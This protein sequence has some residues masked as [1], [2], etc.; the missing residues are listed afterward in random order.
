[1]PF[2]V[3]NREVLT[4]S[5][6]GELSS[7]HNQWIVDII[8]SVER[9]NRLVKTVNGDFVVIP[10]SPAYVL[11][12]KI[13]RPMIDAVID[14]T[15]RLG[16]VILSGCKWLS[17]VNFPPIAAASEIDCSNETC[18][19]N[20]DHALST[21]GPESIIMRRFA[22][23]FNIASDRLTIDACFEATINACRQ[24]QWQQID[25]VVDELDLLVNSQGRTVLLEL[26]EQGE[27]GLVDEL[28]ENGAMMIHSRDRE[29]NTAL[30][31]AAKNGFVYETLAKI[32]SYTEFTENRLGQTP[33]HFA[34]AAGQAISARGLLDHSGFVDRPCKWK[35]GNDIFLDVTPLA[36][37]VINGQIECADLLLEHG[38]YAKFDISNYGGLLHLA[39]NFGQIDMLDH[40]LKEH[41]NKFDLEQRKDRSG[42]TPLMA[43]AYI[44]DLRAMDILLTKGALINAPDYYGRRAIH[45]ATLSHSRNAIKLLHFH[46][47]E[48]SCQTVNGHTPYDL[49]KS[50]RDKASKSTKALLSSLERQSSQ[51]K[52][53]PAYTF[54]A[55]ENLVFQGGGP[56]CIAY[57]GVLKKLES[58][59]FL[60]ELKRVSGTSA[61]SIMASLV[62]LNYPPSDIENNLKDVDFMSF[63]DHP[64]SKK[65]ISETIQDASIGSSVSSLF[66]F[67]NH[68]SSL[69][70]PTTLLSKFIST[71]TGAAK[72]IWS[73]TGI[74][75]GEELRKWV[76]ERIYAS[77][78]VEYLTFGELAQLAEKYT[79]YK[80]LHIHA[81]QLGD[82]PRII[83]INSEDPQWADFII[84][85]TV[86]A[87]ASIPGVFKPHTLHI[88]LS[89]GRRIPSPDY[90]SLV[91]G[92]LLNS[93]PISTFDRDKFVSQVDQTNDFIVNKRTLGIS[94]ATPMASTP[95]HNSVD[96]LG[97]LL[98]SITSLYFNAEEFF[99]DTI[100]QNRFRTIEISPQDATTSSFGLSQENQK[101]LINAGLHA[102]E[103]FYDRQFISFAS[104][105]SIKSENFDFDSKL[106]KRSPNIEGCPKTTQTLHEM[107]I[108]DTAQ[109]RC[110][111]LANS[112]I[113][114]DTALVFAD[115]YQDAFSHIAWLTPKLT[116]THSHDYLPAMRNFA[117]HLKIT[118]SATDTLPRLCH[119]IDLYFKNAKLDKPYLMIYIDAVEQ[120]A[121]PKYS[122]ARLLL[123]S[124]HA[125]LWELDNTLD[126]R[127]IA[128][129]RPSDQSAQIPEEEPQTSTS[130]KK[131]LTPQSNPIPVP[132]LQFTQAKLFE[133]CRSG[134]IELVKSW[135]NDDPSRIQLKEKEGKSLFHAAAGNNQR[136]IMNFL[137]TKSPE[138]IVSLNKNG[139]TPFHEAALEGK[140]QAMEWLY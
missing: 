107:L 8:N 49:L 57:V 115:R 112:N 66:N 45:W 76:E 102:T 14:S 30:H 94:L 32:W 40:L 46:G 137:L 106:P 36:I 9:E 31:Y 116:R 59:M 77:T 123:T 56:K 6:L 1:M 11:G 138:L 133:A 86:V 33:L 88:K 95:E 58:K 84:S 15:Y 41:L 19:Q 126:L 2:A 132:T 54:Y 122:N 64:L 47:A 117:K 83:N 87:S 51:M 37:A 52:K 109:S 128:Y 43:A 69:A 127:D 136:E 79:Y 53:I 39:I 75:D 99:R 113:A 60:S 35:I 67:V 55:P 29:G 21:L 27:E 22:K 70:D 85:D 100:A 5:S 61:G 92:G 68:F 12:E 124:Q 134:D 81:T 89:T 34:I 42:V 129:E 104:N 13:V 48:L 78:G 17:N 18:F 73:T 118:V 74:C 121:L 71:A 93:F 63:L 103:T 50:S 62:A 7:N 96:S 111:L 23:I 101:S 24:G 105:G 119:K 25:S 131:T 135:C 108:K 91:D 120:V 114:Y 44:D 38:A 139:L 140:I 26:I 20:E 125:H 98:I 4:G 3:A 65:K 97:D 80:H 82:H 110:V 28:I 16:Q 10:K 130:K 72:N 90:E